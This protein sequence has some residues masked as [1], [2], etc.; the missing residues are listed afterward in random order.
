LKQFVEKMINMERREKDMRLTEKELEVMAVLWQEGEDA[1]T[2]SEIIASPLKR[3]WKE[4]SI[5]T[6]MNT[7]VK[8]GAVTMAC[9]KPTS[10]ITARAYKT[11]ITPEECMA[12][13]I[14][15]VSSATGVHIDEKKLIKCLLKER[16][17]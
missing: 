15:S 13:H 10:T 17:S 4:N 1:M 12:K 6:I 9:H 7:L 5:F 11:A 16:E 14:A 3:S 8:K 2:T